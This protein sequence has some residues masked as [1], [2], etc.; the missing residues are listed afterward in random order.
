MTYPGVPLYRCVLVREKR[1]VRLSR[2]KLT[3]AW[4]AA[5][6]VGQLTVDSPVEK[7]CCIYLDNAGALIGAEVVATGSEAGIAVTPSAVLRGAIIHCAAAIIIGHNHP[8]DDPEPSASDIE[9]TLAMQFAARSVGIELFDH[10]VV[11][12]SNGHRSI[13]DMLPSW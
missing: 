12:H 3:S 2:A 10:V 1:T 4:Q 7:L 6:I 8:S 11:S 13:R 9:M 5:S